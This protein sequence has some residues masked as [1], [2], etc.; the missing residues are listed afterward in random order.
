VVFQ[1]LG[2][3]VPIRRQICFPFATKPKFHVQIV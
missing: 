1:N 2:R 3:K